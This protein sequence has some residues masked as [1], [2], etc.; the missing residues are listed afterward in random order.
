M[1]KRKRKAKSIAFGVD[2]K[3]EGVRR[4]RGGGASKPGSRQGRVEFRKGFVLR[5]FQTVLCA[6]VLVVDTRLC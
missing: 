2:E 6:C 3:G 4:R 5:H 1:Q